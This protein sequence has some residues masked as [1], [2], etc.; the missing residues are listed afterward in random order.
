MAGLAVAVG[1]FGNTNWREAISDVE[2]AAEE[3]SS[4][5]DEVE[6]SVSDAVAAAN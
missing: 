2:S 3:V 1:E 6:T 5:T 4:A